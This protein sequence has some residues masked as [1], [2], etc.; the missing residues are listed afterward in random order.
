M[1]SNY[2]KLFSFLSELVDFKSDLL[3]EFE[4]FIPEAQPN[5]F[6]QFLHSLYQCY[7]K[8]IPPTR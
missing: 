8:R 5:A 4:Y 2:Q 7:N 1:H 3:N 6:W